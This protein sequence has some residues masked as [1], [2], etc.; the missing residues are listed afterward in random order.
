MF[1]LRFL[2][3]IYTLKITNN[4][5]KNNINRQYNKLCQYNN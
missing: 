2:H 3:K 1:Q 4:H 5:F